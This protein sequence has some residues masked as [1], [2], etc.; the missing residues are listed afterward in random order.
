MGHIFGKRPPILETD[1]KWIYQ[2]PPSDNEDWD[3]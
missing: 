2:P 3:V 1:R